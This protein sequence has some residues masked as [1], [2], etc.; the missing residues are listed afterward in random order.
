[1]KHIFAISFL[2]IFGFIIAGTVELAAQKKN[3]KDIVSIPAGDIKWEE[4]KGGP[5]GIMYSTI[6]GDMTKG[7]YAAFIKLPAGSNH[8]LHIHTNDV[9]LV[10]I[11]GTFWQ[12]LEG[13]SQVKLGPG[14]YL[15]VPGGL[16]HT[17]GVTSDA[18]CVLFQ[19][20]SGMFDLLPVAEGK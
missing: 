6:S 17:S 8:P 15:F 10:V 12:A 13:G 19:E 20:S 9:K 18:D 7:R 5:P 16:R 3:K 1:M 11:S 2:V 4:M 14:S